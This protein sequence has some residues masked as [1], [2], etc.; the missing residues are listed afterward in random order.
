MKLVYFATEEK[1]VQAL[2]LVE[3]LAL[4][5]KATQESSIVKLV[6]LKEE[7]LG[8]GCSKDLSVDDR[9]PS[10]MDLALRVHQSPYACA[11]TSSSFVPT[12]ISS[13]SRQRATIQVHTHLE[14]SQHA[15]YPSPCQ[16]PKASFVSEVQRKFQVKLMVAI[17]HM[18]ADSSNRGIA[19]S[20]HP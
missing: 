9:S 16:I 4:M 10:S 15:F 6:Q 12:T 13:P 11:C 2:K 14:G 8:M 19:T 1:H 20:L 17:G 18:L 3:T 7:L 5:E